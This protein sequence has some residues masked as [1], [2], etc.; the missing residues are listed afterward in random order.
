MKISIVAGLAG[1]LMVSAMHG[2]AAQSGSNGVLGVL[3]PSGT[4]RPV[5]VRPLTSGAAETVTGKFIMK[6][7]ITIASTIPASTPIL[8]DLDTSTLGQN[9]SYEFV[10]EIFETASALATRSGSTAVCTVTLPY[11]WILHLSSDTVSL[12]YNVTAVGSTG[13]D[14]T[15]SIYYETISVPKNGVTTSFDLTGTI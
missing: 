4:F 8:C 2:A 13:T 3:T 10:D 1:M 9:A 5:M 7:T 11:Q 12:S 14:R 15:S 6:L